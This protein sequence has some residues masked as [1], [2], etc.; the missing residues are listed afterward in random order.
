MPDTTLEADVCVVGAGL[1]GLTAARRLS[2]AGQSVVVL[3]ARDRVGGRVWTQESAGGIPVD[4]GGCFIGP[5]H[6]YLRGLAK[7]TGVATFKTFVEG[8]NVLATGGKVRRYR[9]DIP[10]ISPVAL[11]SAGQAIARTSSMAK[12]VSPAAPWDAPRAARWDAQSVRSWLTPGRVPTRMARD[13]MEATVRAC[14]TCDLSEVSMLSWLLLVSSAGGVESLMNIAGGY[15]DSQ[16]E[17]GVGQIPD[18]MARDL[19]DAV[20]LGAPVTA[21]TQEGD[22]VSVVSDPATVTARRVVLA[23]PRALAAGIRVEP[24]LPGDHALLLHK[25]PAG[26]EVKTVAIYDEPFWRA[27]GASGATVATDD[28]I[29]VTLDTTQ[30]GHGHGVIAT[31]SAGPRARALWALPES[32]RRSVLL[33][34]LT[35]RLGPKAAK[36]LEVM[37]LNWSEERW[38]R[39]CSCAHFAPG[40]LTQ[41]GRLLREPVGRIHWAGTE[42]ATTSFGAMDGAV[43]SGERVC[44]EILAAAR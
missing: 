10:R 28:L 13:L 36:P 11:L 14:F 25:M 31:Y 37:E 1:A 33:K 9:G 41:F 27:E 32:E 6:D 4:M 18:V 39:G 19:G 23:L 2:Q 34:M 43:R 22:R 40:V 5:N 44:E 35:T 16:F 12:K 20:V 3:E 21:V 42:T 38:T 30:P 29:E 8:D 26:T 7:E 24:A 15:Q 17:G